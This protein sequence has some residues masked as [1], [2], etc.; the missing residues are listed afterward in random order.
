MSRRTTSLLAAVG[1]TMAAVAVALFLHAPHAGDPATLAITGALVV[2]MG[3][4][5][6][7][8]R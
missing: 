8:A 5:A 7:T 6:A 2:A 3:I 4:Q 1:L